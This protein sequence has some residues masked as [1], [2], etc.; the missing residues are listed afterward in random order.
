LLVAARSLRCREN[1]KSPAACRFYSLLQLIA[2]IKDAL[3]TYY[4]V[5]LISQ[6]SSLRLLAQQVGR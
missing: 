3:E 4:E 5:G 2:V 6:L 1:L